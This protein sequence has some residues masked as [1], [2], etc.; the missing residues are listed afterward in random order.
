MQ[1]IGKFTTEKGFPG[2]AEFLFTR[3]EN[4]CLKNFAVLSTV[5]ETYR[6]QML[7]HLSGLPTLAYES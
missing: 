1:T 6:C 7:R 2:N 3:D 5:T 4:V